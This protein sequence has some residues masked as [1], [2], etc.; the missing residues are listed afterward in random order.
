MSPISW[1]FN[2]VIHSFSFILKQ[3]KYNDV[4]WHQQVVKNMSCFSQ[5]G[6]YLDSTY[7]FRTKCS[8]GTKEQPLHPPCKPHIEV[9]VNIENANNRIRAHIKLKKTLCDWKWNIQ[10]LQ[11]IFCKLNVCIAVVIS[12]DK[13][14]WLLWVSMFNLHRSFS[15]EKFA[16]LWTL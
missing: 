2:K 9:S 13:E 3:T 12:I 5:Q 10:V 4:I 11:I 8:F 6:S 15:L 14:T 16:W 1:H 7:D